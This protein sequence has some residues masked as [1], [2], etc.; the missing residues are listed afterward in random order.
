MKKSNNGFD[1]DYYFR[2]YLESHKQIL[3]S[4]KVAIEKI[5]NG[6]EALSKNHI[7]HD[8]FVRENLSKLGEQNYG[9]IGKLTEYYKLILMLIAI[10]AALV[11]IRIMQGGGA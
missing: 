6:I 7:E 8:Q 4:H 2:Q 9:I 11:G 5:G 3:D 1:M 10:I